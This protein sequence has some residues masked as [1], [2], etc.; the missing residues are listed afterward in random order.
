MK[1]LFSLFIALCFSTLAFGHGDEHKAGHESLEQKKTETLSGQLIGLT[2]FVKHQSK[3][4]SHK[5]CFRECAEK[6]LPIGIL[7]ADKQIYQISGVGHTDLKTTNKQFIKYAEQDVVVKGEI[8]ESNNMNMVV[9]K[10][11]KLAK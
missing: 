3:G 8:F 11:I 2:C 1:L 5:D 10:G 7:T 4:D 6:G 9:V